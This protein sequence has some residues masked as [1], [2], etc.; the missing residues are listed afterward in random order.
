MPD[1]GDFL[2][3]GIVSIGI[4]AVIFFDLGLQSHTYTKA[5]HFWGGPQYFGGV[6]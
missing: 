5:E 1:A 2:C 6:L 4:A 3:E